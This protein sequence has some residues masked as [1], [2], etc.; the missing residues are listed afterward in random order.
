MSE[1]YAVLVIGVFY[2]IGVNLIIR[3][4][5]NQTEKKK[6]QEEIEQVKPRIKELN[7]LGLLSI[8]KMDEER[9]IKS[10]IN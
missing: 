4:V 1:L 5:T 9:N 7:G 3:L 6:I 8:L 2:V 10:S